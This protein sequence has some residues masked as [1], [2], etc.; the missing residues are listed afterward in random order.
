LTDDGLNA[1]EYMKAHAVILGISCTGK[2][3]V[4]YALARQGFL[5][6]NCPIVVGLSLPEEIRKKV[7]RSRVVFL[8]V[9]ADTLME[10]RE[11]RRGYGRV[12]AMYTDYDS[13]AGEVESARAQ[14][15]GHPGWTCITV[16]SVS[17][18]ETA[19]RIV[20]ILEDRFEF[21]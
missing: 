19:K 15:Y 5:V 18:E 8:E 20:E 14:L 16:D 2:S 1:G 17:A 13:I 10:R 4:A 12:R 3:T 11:S 6:A 21:V 9:E 7:D